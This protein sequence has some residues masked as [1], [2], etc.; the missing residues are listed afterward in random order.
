ME[1]YENAEESEKPKILES[2]N[3]ERTN[4]A[5]KII[6]LNKEMSMKYK[7]FEQKLRSEQ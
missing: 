2:I 7:E 6:E 1:F 3:E 5:Q 4:S